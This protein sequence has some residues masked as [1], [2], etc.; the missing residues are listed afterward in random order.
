MLIC[1]LPFSLHF[2]WCYKRNGGKTLGTL[3]DSKQR[4]QIVLVAIVSIQSQT[5]RRK[6]KSY[7]KMFLMNKN[8]NY[9]KINS[10]YIYLQYCLIKWEVCIKFTF[11]SKYNGFLRESTLNRLNPKW[12]TTF[13]WKNWQRN[14]SYLHLSIWQEVFKK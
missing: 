9:I 5:H 4:H 6:K 1:H 14:Y 2:H 10:E 3:A 8:I 13:T 12:S 11:T 7:L